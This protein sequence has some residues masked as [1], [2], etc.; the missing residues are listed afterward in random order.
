V[1]GKKTK[2]QQNYDEVLFRHK[3]KLPTRDAI[4]GPV[5]VFFFLSFVSF[6]DFPGARKEEEEDT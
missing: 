2:L 6:F 5:F 3:R 4:V 1:V